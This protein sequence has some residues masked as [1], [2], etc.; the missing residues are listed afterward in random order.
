MNIKF[1]KITTLTLALFLISG[2][3]INF[4]PS[5]KD[6]V[7]GW[8]Q[9]SL[10]NT[11][12]AEEI[13]PLFFCPCCGQPLDKKNICCEM[14]EEMI[15]YIDSLVDRNLSEEEE[16]I[17]SFAK[18]YGLNSFVDGNKAIEV[19]ENLARTA[20]DERPQIVIEPETYDFG[21][22]SQKKGN[23]FT[24]FE[25]KNIGEKDLVIDR[26]DTSCGCT[27]A[28]IVYKDKESPF[29]TM[30]GHGYENPEWEGVSI[31]AGETAQLKV[32]YDP[33]IHGEFRGF[34]I[35]EVSIYSNDPIDFEKKIRIELNQ[36]E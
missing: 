14:A 8:N 16:A 31:S 7:A 19:R 1:W 6:R 9:L 27:F 30:P 10:V 15:Y 23:V 24:Y 22:I 2:L 3:A 18:E 11:V 28:A 34:A 17:I 5:L 26:M 4:I 20:P 32:M 36:V 12:L 33:D 25:L 29:F 13:Y 21:D 35:R